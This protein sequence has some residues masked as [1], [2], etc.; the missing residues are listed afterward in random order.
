MSSPK[1]HA[2]WGLHISE[3]FF[4]D[5]TN[6]FFPKDRSLPTLRHVTTVA[7]PHLERIALHGQPSSETI[8]MLRSVLSL[9]HRPKELHCLTNNTLL[10]ACMKSLKT[11]YSGNLQDDGEELF[12]YEFG[13]LCFRVI[14]LLV[15]VG[16]LARANTL[17]AFASSK[18]DASDPNSTS[19]ALSLS[20]AQL[21]LDAAKEENSRE[22]LFGAFKSQTG[23]HISLWTSGNVG[24]VDVEF[25]SR[26]IWRS[27]K[28]L[29]QICTNVANTGWSFA[30]LL[31]GEHLR[32]ALEAGECYYPYEWVGL[33]MLCYRQILVAPSQ[34]EI[35]YLTDICTSAEMLRIEKTEELCADAIQDLEDAKILMAVLA[36]RMN[37]SLNV[38]RLPSLSAESIL[39]W[40][41]QYHIMHEFTDLIP[42]F[43]EATY[44]WI[45]AELS[46]SIAQGL[47]MNN[48]LAKYASHALD[49]TRGVYKRRLSS[50]QRASFTK[51]LSELDFVNL[52]G[53]LILVPLE[54]GST[55]LNLPAGVAHADS[56]QDIREDWRGV[57]LEIFDFVKVYGMT[58][59]S[60]NRAF[61][62]SYPD[63]L[64]TWH[65]FDIH[66]PHHRAK[67]Q[68]INDWANACRF[69][70]SRLGTEFGYD[71]RP[72]QER[73][74]CAYMRCPGVV[75][76]FG[77]EFAC[78][79]MGVAYCSL[80]CQH[81]HWLEPTAGAHRTVCT[82]SS[83][84]V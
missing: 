38:A 56:F 50:H 37:P 82:R 64:K 40:F 43:L 80:R 10:T 53:R 23:E 63:W 58:A 81:A 17:E 8:D 41:I 25:L 83:G 29:L 26:F 73:F 72:Y 42:E 78:E 44:S 59:G 66:F 57:Q 61:A 79:C 11:S 13:F 71:V 47:S 67:S 39:G 28:E 55:I 76:R 12:A 22:K 74:E 69:L 45:W 75:F 2:I 31:L 46:D 84:D 30:L 21:V 54:L 3:Y 70:W 27:R 32:W 7:I 49:F 33:Q 1:K 16:I 65:C 52:M 18:S 51:L 6:A 60:S 62:S 77:A 20:A 34:M 9:I 48:Q 24:G 36:H 14:L 5:P 68:F 15:Q 4:K 35:S 19:A